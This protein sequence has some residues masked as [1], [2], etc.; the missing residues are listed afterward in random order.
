MQM[1]DYDWFDHYD[2]EKNGVPEITSEEIAADA[3]AKRVQEQLGITIKPMHSLRRRTWTRWVAGAAAAAVL[4]TGGTMLS[5]AAGI[6]G[7]EAFFRSLFSKEVPEHPEK[8]ESLVTVPHAVIDSTNA[9]VQFALLGM[10][11]DDSQALLSFS[12]TASGVSLTDGLKI[13]YQLS[14][15]DTD[16]TVLL[17][18][19][20]DGGT[21][22]ELREKNGAY[23]LNL[24]I[25]EAVDILGTFLDTL[26]F[27]LSGSFFER[28]LVI[29]SINVPL[30]KAYVSTFS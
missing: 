4:V 25:G 15:L 1:N 22:A 16:G 17:E 12:V 9:Q 6:G 26:N 3:V 23:Y 14:V 11:G 19:A 5:T 10:Y 2:A 29:V 21:V 20:N 24:S 27:F 18:E 8:M 13:P 7:T 28:L 30:S